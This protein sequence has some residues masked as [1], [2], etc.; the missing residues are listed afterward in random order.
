MN[1]YGFLKKISGSARD[2][3]KIDAEINQI[4]DLIHRGYSK[5]SISKNHRDNF[6]FLFEFAKSRIKV[7]RKFS[8]YDHLFLDYYSSMYSTPEIIG[9]YRAGKLSGKKIVDA[10]SGAGM[11]DIMLSEFCD[12]TG[13]EIDHD[14]HLMGELNKIPYNSKANFIREDFFSVKDSFSKYVLFSDPLRPVNSREKTFSQLSPNP[15]DIISNSP[16]IE[17][18]AIDL[19]PHM[20]WENILLKGEKEYISLDGSLNRLT[21]YSPSISEKNSTAVILPENIII[22]G[23]PEEFSPNIEHNNRE[24]TYVYV[25]DTSLFC[26][27]LLHLVV[28]PDWNTLYFDNRR[29]VFS[30]NVYEES[31]PGKQYAVLDFSSDANLTPTL[32]KLDAGK[33]F[34]RFSMSPDDTY[35]YKNSLERELSGSKNIY[36]FRGNSKYIITEKVA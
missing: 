14:R 19:P 20:K 4:V 17:G 28:K 34:F 5:E 13:V 36:I 18:Y 29:Q 21:L 15:L 27:K 2:Y 7:S 9:K 30:G 11:Q 16:G 23:E 31:F 12:V 8:K 35:R 24:S 26:A 22:S 6:N 33:V 25:P 1:L 3:E 32:Q 10:G